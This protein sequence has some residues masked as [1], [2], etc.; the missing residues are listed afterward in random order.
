[1]NQP[2]TSS[3]AT[4][5]A[6]IRVLEERFPPYDPLHGTPSPMVRRTVTFELP[7]GLSKWEQTDY[8]HPGVFNPPQHRS[9]PSSL[10]PKTARL[11]AAVEAVAK[12]RD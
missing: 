6:T 11:Q 3:A 5:E 9:M 2:T 10:Q 8:G 7:E 1:M 12:L 4:R